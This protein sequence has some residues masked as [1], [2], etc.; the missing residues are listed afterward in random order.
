MDDLKLYRKNTKQLDLL[1]QTFWVYLANI[2]MEFGITKCAV[3]ELV[4]AMGA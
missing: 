2:G 1:V 3:L 4:R